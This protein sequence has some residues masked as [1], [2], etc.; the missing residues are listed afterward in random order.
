M[1]GGENFHSGAWDHRAISNAVDA[2]RP[3]ESEAVAASWD[4]LGRKFEESVA[5]FHDATRAAVDTGW[6]GQSATAVVSAL[7]DYA[8]RAG[9]VGGRFTDVGDALRHASAGAEAVR[10]A[11]GSPRDHPIDWT[12]VLPGNWTAEAD[13]DAAEQDAK[14]AMDT[15]YASAYRVADEQLPTDGLAATHAAATAHGQPVG[16]DIGPNGVHGI[17]SDQ[18]V[19]E[20]ESELGADP[21]PRQS[22]EVPPQNAQAAPGSIA[23]AALAGAVGGGVAQYAHGIVAAHR[24]PT[25]DRPGG[26]ALPAAREDE[27][28]PRTYLESIDAGSEL[29]GKLPLVT[30]AVIGE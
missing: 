3:A 30:P 4:D 2:L 14:A 8:A 7:D 28:E 9:Q 24:A 19:A 16:F 18:Q 13:A 5:A 25:S 6:R 27:E 1:N 21:D 12:R 11:V 10:G 26:P 23:G 15:L 17:P 22:D 20:S 29:V